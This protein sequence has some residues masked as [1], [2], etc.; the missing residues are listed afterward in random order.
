MINLFK[1]TFRYILLHMLNYIP[2]VQGLYDEGVCKEPRSFAFVPD[3]FKT[4]EINN[5][6]VEKHPNTL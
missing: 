1:K 5:N 3:C 6:A 4:E 2:G